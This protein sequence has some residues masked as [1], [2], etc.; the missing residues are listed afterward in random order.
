MIMT[1]EGTFYAIDPCNAYP[2]KT[3]DELFEALGILPHW[4]DALDKRPFREQLEANY[5]FPCDWSSNDKAT[6]SNDLQFCYPDDDRLGAVAVCMRKPDK[7]F[8]TAIFY[9]GAIVAI[10][11]NHK[12]DAWCIMD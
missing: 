5:A 6:L 7:D 8:E 10:L 9:P 1:T 4:I 12:M 2:H 11:T 3:D